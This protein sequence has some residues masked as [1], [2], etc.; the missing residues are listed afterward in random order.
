MRYE[1]NYLGDGLHFCRERGSLSKVYLAKV[2][3]KK[4]I[5]LKILSSK[6]YRARFDEDVGGG[7]RLELELGFI[8]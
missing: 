7:R 1:S 4:F 2:F 8:F 3:R 5:S 6:F